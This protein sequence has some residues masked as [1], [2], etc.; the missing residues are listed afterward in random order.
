[1]RT[2]QIRFKDVVHANLYF[3][4]KPGLHVWLC[5]AFPVESMRLRFARLLT[6]AYPEQSLKHVLSAT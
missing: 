6:V 5:G 3:R 1:M 2:E 4:G